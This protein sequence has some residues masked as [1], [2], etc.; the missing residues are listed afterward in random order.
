MPGWTSGTS[1]GASASLAVVSFEFGHARFHGRLIQP[2]LD[3]G[4]DARDRALDLCK[5]PPFKFGAPD[6]PAI[7][8]GAA[9]VMT[10]ATVAVSRAL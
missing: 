2:I 6:R 3:R 10:N 8:A 1:C 5:R 9:T 7:G 4:H